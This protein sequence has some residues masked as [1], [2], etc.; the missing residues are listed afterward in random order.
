MRSTVIEISWGTMQTPPRSP[1]PILYFHCPLP[2][3]LLAQ[4]RHHLQK[5]L[6][7]SHSHLALYKEQKS[8]SIHVP[9]GAEANDLLPFKVR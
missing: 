8:L 5:L 2:Y 1:L 6:L 3:A 7:G 4:T 9:P